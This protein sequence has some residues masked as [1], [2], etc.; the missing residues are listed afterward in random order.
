MAWKLGGW[1]KLLLACFLTHIANKFCACG[2]RSARSRLVVHN[3]NAKKEWSHVEALVNML[4]L[5]N[6]MV[7]SLHFT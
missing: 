5:C 4:A 2:P 6:R 1:A 7:C 3:T